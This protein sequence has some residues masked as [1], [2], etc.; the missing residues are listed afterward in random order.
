MKAFLR[1]WT[2]AQTFLLETE[3]RL[4]TSSV[5]KENNTSRKSTILNNETKLAVIQNDDHKN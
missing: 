4:K 5:L 1:D 2:S 3:S